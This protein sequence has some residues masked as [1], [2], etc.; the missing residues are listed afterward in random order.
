MSKPKCDIHGKCK[1]S[2]DV[3]CE[4]GNAFGCKDYRDSWRK[5]EGDVDII[6]DDVCRN[7]TYPG[8]NKSKA[9]YIH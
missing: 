2:K 5:G 9:E 4:Y 1:A 7:L 3:L 6:A 8:H